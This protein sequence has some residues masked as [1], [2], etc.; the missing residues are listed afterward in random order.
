MMA[1]D[2]NGDDVYCRVTLSLAPPTGSNRVDVNFSLP[3]KQLTFTTTSDTQAVLTAQTIAPVTNADGWGFVSVEL[4]S[5]TA[6]GAQAL[7]YGLP[8]F[9]LGPFVP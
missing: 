3:Y 1:S 2:N 4:A 7:F 5:D 6:H 9:Y 8:L